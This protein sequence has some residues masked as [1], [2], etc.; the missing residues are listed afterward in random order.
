MAQGGGSSPSELTVLV[1]SQPP[2][3]VLRVLMASRWRRSRTCNGGDAGGSADVGVA[4]EFLDH[5]EVDALFQ[6]QGGGRVAEV[7]KP[8][9]TQSCAVEESAEA[10]GEVG[11]FERAVG[12]GGEDEAVVRPA[13]PRGPAY[14]LLLFPMGLQGV[15]AFGGEDDATFG[16]AGS[17]AACEKVAG[18]AQAAADKLRRLDERATD[19]REELPSAEALLRLG[20]AALEYRGPRRAGGGGTPP[21]ANGVD[22]PAMRKMGEA[23]NRPMPGAKR[24]VSAA[25][26]RG[27][28]APGPVARRRSQTFGAAWQ[29]PCTPT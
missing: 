29:Y 7:V 22:I 1:V 20:D 4:E 2:S 24:G 6:K 16:S 26:A 18:W 8:D 28:H 25:A 13:R 11:R 3:A 23:L 14:F 15:D 27:L 17:I 10:A 12:G 9:A 5:H 21:S 19:R